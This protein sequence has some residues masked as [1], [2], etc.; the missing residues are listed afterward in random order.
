MY[1]S[2][3]GKMLVAVATNGVPG[4]FRDVGNVPE[5]TLALETTTLERKESRSGQR[6]IALRL[7][8]EKKGSLTAALEDFMTDNLALGLYGS[9]AVVAASTVTGEA[10]PD[11]LVAGDLVRLAQPNVSSVVVEDSA[12]V[13]VA[14]TQGTHYEI[15]SADHGTLRILDPAAFT[16]PFTVDYSYDGH[17]NVGMFTAAPPELW[18]RFEG[19]NTADSNKPV[20]IELYKVLFDPLGN[21]GLIS[22]ELARIDLS[23]SVLYDP[24]KEND[25]TLGQF[26]RIVQI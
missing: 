7:I 9:K 16:Q 10:L 12:G 25:A 8:T 11:A 4:A 22:D 20:L 6:L 18:V 1:F 23:G 19:L 13:P 21:L 24:T 26:G 15:A 3:Q 2:G 5:L 14:L 17:I